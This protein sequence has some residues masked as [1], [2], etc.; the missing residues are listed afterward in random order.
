MVRRK[1]EIIKIEYWIEISDVGYIETKIE[2]NE[3]SKI[4]NCVME[5]DMKLNYPNDIRLKNAEF[6]QNE[7]TYSN[8]QL[9]SKTTKII[10]LRRLENFMV[11]I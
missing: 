8:E 6:L 5:S 10:S 11:E 4:E 2:K 7:S 1:N 9:H 3:F